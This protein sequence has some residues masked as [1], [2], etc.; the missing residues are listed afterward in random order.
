MSVNTRPYRRESKNDRVDTKALLEA[1]R[2][3][4]IPIAMMAYRSDRRG[5]KPMTSVALR[6]LAPIGSPRANFHH[7][8]E[9]N[10]APIKRRK[11][12]LQSDPLVTTR[13]GRAASRK[14]S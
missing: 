8:P 10:R 13:D 14:I 9:P 4:A 1:Y 7:G 6:G 12:R 11:I 2:P 3:T 5:G